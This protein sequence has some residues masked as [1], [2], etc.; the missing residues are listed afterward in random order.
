MIKFIKSMK[1]FIIPNWYRYVLVVFFGLALDFANLVPAIIIANLT[2][3]IEQNTL[4]THILIYNILL[5]F[6]GTMIGIY[7]LATT[8]RFCQN[9]LK[10]PYILPYIEDIWHLFYLKMRHSLR[11]IKLVTF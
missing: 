1:W 5:P 10:L 4:T 2:R 6:V 9:R 3:G 8:K 7:I 11:N